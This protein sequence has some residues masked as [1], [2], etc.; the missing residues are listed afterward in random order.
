MPINQFVSAASGPR[1]E[2]DVLIV[3]VYEEQLVVEK[4]LVLKEEL[5]IRRI[6]ASEEWSE[7]VT[8]RREEVEIER[9]AGA[10]TTVQENTSHE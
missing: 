4:R 1:E 8:L 9:V 6:R 5:H 10:D 7:P 3:P 2:G